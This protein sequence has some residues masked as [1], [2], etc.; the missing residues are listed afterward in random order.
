MNERKALLDAA[1][2]FVEDYQHSGKNCSFFEK[3]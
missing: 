3:R 2:A 1:D